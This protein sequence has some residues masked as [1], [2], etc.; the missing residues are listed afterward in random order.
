[1]TAKWMCHCGDQAAWLF[2]I[3]DVDPAGEERHGDG[4]SACD[5]H[6]AEG[7]RALID[8]QGDRP[9]GTYSVIVRGP[10]QAVVPA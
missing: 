5:T 7:A 9:R 6:M 10:D 8:R 3:A 1:M 4:Y 2:L